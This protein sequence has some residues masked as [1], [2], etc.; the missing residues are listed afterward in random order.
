MVAGNKCLEVTNVDETLADAE[1]EQLEQSAREAKQ[2]LWTNPAPVPPWVYRKARGGQSL[3]LLDL[4]PLDLKLNGARL[5]VALHSLELSR[6]IPSPLPIGNRRSHIQHPPGCSNSNQVAPH[7]R[8][9][10]N[11]TAEAKATGYRLAG[12]CP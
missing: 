8:V 5:L 1:L 6:K 7:N 12:S 3:D 2:G 4:M 9:E 10:F 11:S